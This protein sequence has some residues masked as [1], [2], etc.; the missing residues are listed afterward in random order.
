DAAA[1][2]R[3]GSSHGHDVHPRLL[4]AMPHSLAVGCVDAA[5]EIH[6]NVLHICIPDQEIGFDSGAQI[7]DRIVVDPGEWRRR[8]LRRTFA[9]KRPLWQAIGIPGSRSSSTSAERQS[10]RILLLR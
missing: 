7:T 3:V 9:R 5:A 6:C 1:T 10:E 8:L 2:G 4:I